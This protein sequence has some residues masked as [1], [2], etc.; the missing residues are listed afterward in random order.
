[1][2]QNADFLLREVQRVTNFLS[3]LIHNICSLNEYNIEDSIKETD[4]FIKEN[5]NFSFQEITT[6]SDTALL[7]KL[8]NIPEI[9]IEKFVGL[10]NELLKHSKQTAI[11]KEYNWHEIARKGSV[12]LVELEKNTTVF[13][14]QRNQ[15]KTA[16]EGYRLQ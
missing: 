15:L 10:L 16:L 3:K 11:K 4:D 13:S 5:W 12:I 7:S 14:L 2:E 8:E 9:H 1:M 6:L